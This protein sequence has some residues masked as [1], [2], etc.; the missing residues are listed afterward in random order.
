MSW[1]KP[2]TFGLSF[3]LT[4]LTVVWLSAYLPLSGR[5]RGWL[6]GI[7]A[8][9][10]CAEVAGFLK[11]VHALG[12]HGVL[13]LPALA[14]LLSRTGWDETRRTRTVAVAVAVAVYGASVA[15]A[16]AYSLV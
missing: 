4:L 6:L 3:G 16:A 1:R 5:R 14:W 13:V 10:C 8:V 2:I 7:F 12:L 15:A 9:D 11:P